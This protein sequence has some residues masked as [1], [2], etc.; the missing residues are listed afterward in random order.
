VEVSLPHVTVRAEDF[1]PASRKAMERSRRVLSDAPVDDRHVEAL[2]QQVLPRA[3]VRE[4]D[5]Q[6]ERGLGITL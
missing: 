2:G 6:A 3:L 4:G 1:V 5:S